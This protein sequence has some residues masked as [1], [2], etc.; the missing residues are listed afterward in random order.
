MPPELAL[1]FFQAVKIGLTP[2]GEI[3]ADRFMRALG[4]L[5]A[6]GD[7]GKY[8]AIFKAHWSSR[9]G[10]LKAYQ[11]RNAFKTLIGEMVAGGVTTLPSRSTVNAWLDRSFVSQLPSR[12][13]LQVSE[14]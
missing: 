2:Q 10:E 4:L 11:P 9:Y 5:N 6:V 12:E 7:D 1:W 8:S 13:Y 14:N 3:N